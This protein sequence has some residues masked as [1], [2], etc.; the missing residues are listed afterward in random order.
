MTP[1]GFRRKY[2]NGMV[3]TVHHNAEE[4]NPAVDFLPGMVTYKLI[5]EHES[6]KPEY[7]DIADDLLNNIQRKL[8][9]LKLLKIKNQGMDGQD[10]V[11]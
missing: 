8:Q 11:G 2:K 7:Q 1:K 4:D 10:A 9:L 3:V 5:I 6:P